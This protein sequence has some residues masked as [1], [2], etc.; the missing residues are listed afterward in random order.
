M[1]KFLTL[2]MVAAFALGA[3]AAED[4]KPE[5]K[6]NT[7]GMACCKKEGVANCKDCKE[8]QA[9][10]AAPKAEPKKS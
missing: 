8:C 5:P 6:A 1:K 10:K 2:A 9:K 7:C 3:Y 4:K